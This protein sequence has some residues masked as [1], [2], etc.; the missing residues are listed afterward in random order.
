METNI[1]PSIKKFDV[2]DISGRKK[3]LC[4]L[5][6]GFENR[7]LSFIF[8]CNKES[9]E[10]I[11]ICKYLPHKKSKYN[12]LN[13]FLEKNYNYITKKEYYFDRYNPFVFEMDIQKEFENS[14]TYEEI[15]IDI[16]VMSK[17]MI[18][19]IICCLYGY[20]GIIRII[21]TEPKAYAPTEEEFRTYNM[22][23]SN[24]ATLPSY[25]VHDV[26]RTPLLISTIMQKSPILLVSF[27]SFNEQLI[28]ALLSECNPTHLYLI[29]GVP[30]YLG[31]REKALVDIHE[32][33]I[34]D[35]SI[36]NPKDDKGLLI[37]KSSTLNYQ[38]TIALLAEIYREHCIK[39]KIILAPT[40]SKMQTIGCALMKLC[41][42]DI[43]IEY[44]IPESYYIDGY[45]S[46]DIRQIH[47]V[48]I[49]NI[50]ELVEDISNYYKLNQ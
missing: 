33:I 29:N 4:I 20:K 28:R 48:I 21:Y 25:G 19:Q 44:P 32:N 10:K 9:F 30:P 1:I 17:Y 2:N 43:H 36:D 6:E 24:A 37:R 41:C 27:L 42:P 11:I 16:S 8:S 7:S 31:W 5:S 49:K 47:E 34:C 50:M 13:T 35:Y 23:Q 3:R 46:S 26:I 40:G 15:I 45:S 14:Y 22:D 12:E 38:E 39:N 18:M